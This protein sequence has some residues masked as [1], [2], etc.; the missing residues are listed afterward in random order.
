MKVV[1]SF[2]GSGLLWCA[3]AGLFAP[4]HAQDVV[5]LDLRP[6]SNRTVLIETVQEAVNTYR[7]LED[8]GLVARLLAAGRTFP[9]MVHMVQRKTLRQVAGSA[10]PDGSFDLELS[11]Q[12]QSRVQKLPDGSER[13][14][15]QQGSMVGVTVKAGV[16]G[17]GKLRRET[18]R[19]SGA[20]EADAENLRIIMTSVMEQ[21]IA[22]SPQEIRRDRS[23]TQDTRLQVPLD[24]IAVMDVAI[25][26]S[27]RLAGVHEGVAD[28]H[29]VY[30]MAFGLATGPANLK[31]QAEGAGGG[32]VR[33]DLVRRL[34]LGN[35]SHT[36][37]TFTLDMPEAMLV[38]VMNVKQVQTA[39]ESP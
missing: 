22:I 4:A 5:L 9:S 10:Q 38:M 31:V 23:T 34:V 21:A 35:E 26:V 20:P 11:V 19:V 36:L 27:S 29:M 15:P 25:N 18:L 32:T 6:Q 13:E 30:S 7:I 1:R 2:A 8:R 16:T 39:R 12:S 24:S 28:I 17:D 14:L 37:M 33:Y 3:W